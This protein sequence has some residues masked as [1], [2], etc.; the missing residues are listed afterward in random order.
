M[1]DIGTLAKQYR[2]SAAL[3]K[4]RADR[5]V[6]LVHGE[7]SET[8]RYKMR[9]RIDTLM[10]MYRETSEVALILEKYYDR[11]YRRN[12]RYKI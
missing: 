2:E 1:M 7:M 5:L 4:T 10:G 9:I 12:E 3:L 8:E 11:S 6:E